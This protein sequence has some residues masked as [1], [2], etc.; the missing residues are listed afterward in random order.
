MVFPSDTKLEV[1][2]REVRE[3]N[4]GRHGSLQNQMDRAQNR[5]SHL[6]R[7]RKNS[8]AVWRKKGKKKALDVSRLVP[9]LLETN[10]DR[11][12]TCYSENYQHDEAFAP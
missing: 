12:L 7:N 6:V 4:T 9:V 10:G 8:L 5:G 11:L 1:V 3:K 2:V